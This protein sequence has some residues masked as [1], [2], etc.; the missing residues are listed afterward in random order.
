M[1]RPA[2]LRTRGFTLLELLVVLAVIAILATLSIPFLVRS[3]IAASEEGAIAALRQVLQ[4]QM[5]FASR[6]TADLNTNG[7][8]EYAT[9]GELSGRV[10]I[11]AAN[12]GS[13]FLSPPYLSAS[14]GTVSPAGEAQRGGYFFRIFLPDA[15]GEGLPELPGGGTDAAVDPARGESLWCAYAWPRVYGST[16]SRTFFVNQAGQMLWTD[17]PVYSGEGAGIAPG[18]ALSEGGTPEQIAGV[19]AA[20]GVGRDGRTWRPVGG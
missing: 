20:G 19:P 17:D 10:A 4:S 16:G 18:S 15:S 7:A 12:G 13:T 14:F 1:L 5:Q 2:A 3:R 11:R 8:G 6:V 9:F